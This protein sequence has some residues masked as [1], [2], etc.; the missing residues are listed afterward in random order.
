M[1]T[2]FSSPIKG[3]NAGSCQRLADY[4][5]KE[6]NQLAPNQ[7]E[8]FFCAQHDKVSVV[9]V[10]AS[11][12]QNGAAQG[13][14]SGQ[15]RFY[16]FT[17]DPSQKELAHIAGDTE[18]LRAYTRQVM[19]NYAA[20]FGKGIESGDLVWFAKIEHSRSYSHTDQ[21]VQDGTA[22]KGQ[23]KEGD[24]THVHVIVSRFKERE[25]D[26]ERTMSLSPLTNH[27]QAGGAIGNGFDRVNFIQANERSF[28][29]LTGYQREQTETFAHAKAATSAH[30]I[31]RLATREQAIKASIERDRP[32]QIEP[33]R[34]RSHQPD[35]TQS[36]SLSL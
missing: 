3:A 24:Q 10:V 29:A 25:H 8:E 35:Q 21:A 36:N 16:T 22:Q 15:D 34:E 14:K 7:R 33:L 20:N 30:Q 19:E 18:Q 1:V 11:I 31:D 28:D 27:R 32:Q 26:R 13:L 6:N 2:N 12:D 4:L 5:E 23:P 17:V 9:D